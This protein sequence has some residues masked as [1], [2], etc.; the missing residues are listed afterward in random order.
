MLIWLIASML[1]P[2]LNPQVPKCTSPVLF[3]RKRAGK[4]ACDY[5]IG[6]A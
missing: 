5:G 1:E 3:W 2:P 6:G 4:A